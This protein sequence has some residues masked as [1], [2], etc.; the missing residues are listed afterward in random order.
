MSDADT[1]SIE[2]DQEHEDSGTGGLRR[3]MEQRVKSLQDAEERIRREQAAL[4]EQ[5]KVVFA[6]REARLA[7]REKELAKREATLAV[8]EGIAE[9]AP[10]LARPD[11]E[12]R[13]RAS[14]PARLRSRS[15]LAEL[16]SR[17]QLTGEAPAEHS[18]AEA[19][20]VAELEGTIAAL[21]QQL[22]EAATNASDS[23]SAPRRC[24][25]PSWTTASTEPTRSSGCCSSASCN[26][27]GAKADLEQQQT[28]AREIENS[29]NEREQA[30]IARET[31]AEQ[32]LQRAEQENADGS[33]RSATCSGDG[34][35]RDAHASLTEIEQALSAREAPGRVG[36]GA[37]GRGQG[38]V[39]APGLPRPRRR[40]SRSSSAPRSWRISSSAWSRSRRG[41][42]RWTRPRRG[43]PPSR[44]RWTAPTLGSSRRSRSCPR[45]RRSSRR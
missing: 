41:H 17:E 23:G 20:R 13:E 38:R 40:C 34:R 29:L 18:A 12:E 28:A 3:A 11:L 6:E 27:D 24:A 9:G 44:R 36:R 43:W 25:Q 26:I 42:A 35:D 10:D 19:R 5:A 22:A 1:G 15:W 37:A 45:P 39:R 14:R 31:E 32:A 2:P 8:S 21:E 33:S 16:E 30:L 4:Q 7:R